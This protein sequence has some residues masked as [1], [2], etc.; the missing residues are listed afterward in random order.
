MNGVETISKVFPDELLK[1]IQEEV[2]RVPFQYG[3]HSNK[4]IEYTHWN[5]SFARAGADNTLDV[6]DEISGVIKEAWDYLQANHLGPQAL[7][8]CYVNAHTYGIEGY[9]HT[10]SS[11]A[12][13]KTVLVYLTPNWQINWGG[14]TVV[15]DGN[16]IGH[17]ELPRENKGLVFPGA[18][19]H[20]ARAV[21]RIC[22]ALRLTLMFKFAPKDY[23]PTRDNLQR[24]LVAL[25]TNKIK[26]SKNTLKGHLLR[27]YDKLR[28]KGYSTTVCAA[29]ALHSIFGTNAFKT[30]VLPRDKE[31][32][33]AR[34]VGKEVIELV[35]LFRD[36]KRPKTLEH[37]LA[38]NTLQVELNDGGTRELT[39]EQ[40]NSLCAI[41]AANLLDQRANLNQYPHLSRIMPK[42]KQ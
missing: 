4:G 16:D 14:E 28:S 6:S 17:A 20:C 42:D 27:T 33:L 19:L 23:D 31:E 1:R 12:L 40:L 26:H 21:T 29:G 9:P 36:I 18:R 2:S 11:R 37:A 35:T 13:D 10:D 32:A 38:T 39:K 8:R 24:L 3:W 25:G 34:L 7:L 22:P 41:E 5:H 30:A 15:Y